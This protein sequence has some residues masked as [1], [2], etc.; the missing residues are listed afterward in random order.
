MASKIELEIPT[1]EEAAAK[2]EAERVANEA[3][4]R[5]R[6]AAENRAAGIEEPKPGTR[7][8]VTTARGIARRSRAGCTFHSEGKELVLVVDEHHPV[9]R[10]KD[11]AGKELGGWWVN[12]YGAETILA[13]TGLNVT[14]QGATEADASDLRKQLAAKDAEL[15][16]LKAEHHRVLRDA[17]MGAKDTGDGSPARLLAA[18][19]ARMGAGPDPDF[20]GGGEK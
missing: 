4:E 14:S 18:R 7:L 16:A 3:K 13:D 11:D 19:K 9:G 12:A 10:I 6:Q 8:F 5:A 1:Q 17:R 15:A 2:L 20:G